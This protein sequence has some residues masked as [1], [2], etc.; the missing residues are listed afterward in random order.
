MAF[1]EDLLTRLERA[2]ER[3]LSS[4][5]ARIDLQTGAASLL[6][7]IQGKVVNYF[8]EKYQPVPDTW[9]DDV[10]AWGDTE[11]DLT[12][13]ITAYEGPIQ[14]VR[15]PR[16]GPAWDRRRAACPPAMEHRQSQARRS[17]RPTKNCPRS[18][19]G[20]MQRN[21]RCGDYS[22]SHAATLRIAKPAAVCHHDIPIYDAPR[23][24]QAGDRNA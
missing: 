16:R 15:I 4:Y 7:Q 5:P 14:V 18:C 2:F 1:E 21:A 23:A 8:V 19:S 11:I 24:V 22:T 9:A 10:Y 3:N 17:K 12:V 6:A 20:M 13:P